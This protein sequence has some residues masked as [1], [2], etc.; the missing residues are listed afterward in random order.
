ML[1]VA[2]DKLPTTGGS[3]KVTVNLTVEIIHQIFAE[4]PAVHLAYRKLVPNKMSEIEFWTKYCN[5]EFLYRKKYVVAAVTAA[6]ADDDEAIGLL[7]KRD[8]ILALDMEPDEGDDYMHLQDHK[9]ICDERI[10]AIDLAYDE[11]TR[12]L[13]QNLNQHAA[14]G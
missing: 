7:F 10:E 3:N 8:E 9:I 6:A 13:F 12:T 14:V 5:A 4:K 11:H 1:E 2:D